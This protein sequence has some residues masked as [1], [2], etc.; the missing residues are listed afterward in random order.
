[1]NLL[2]S[3]T[4]EVLSEN[5]YRCVRDDEDGS[6]RSQIRLN[7]GL[8][9][10]VLDTGPDQ[11][12]IILYLYLPE[13]I[14]EPR[15]FGVMEYFTRVNHNL[16]MGHFEIDLD[17]GKARFVTG[18]LVEDDNLPAPLLLALIRNALDR[19]E[20][21]FPGLLRILHGGLHPVA[22]LDEIEQRHGYAGRHAGRYVSQRLN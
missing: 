17:D 1:M 20:T 14:P 19:V 8:Y 21:F 16:P 9:G 3:L 4:D 12:E 18:Q 6:L 7:S 11:Q 13:K 5:G 10:L 22:A 15:R 2:A